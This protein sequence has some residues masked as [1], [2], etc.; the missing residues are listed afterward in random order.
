[1][2]VNMS[3]YDKGSHETRLASASVRYDGE[4]NL[5]RFRGDGTWL[6]FLPSDHNDWDPFC[7]STAR[8]ISHHTETSAESFRR[9]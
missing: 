8:A 5:P 2:V 3:F 4:P 6:S 7:L 9:D 1:M